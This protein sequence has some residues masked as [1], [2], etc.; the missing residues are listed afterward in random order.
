MS[1]ADTKLTFG[2]PHTNRLT[3]MGRVAEPPFARHDATGAAIIVPLNLQ[4]HRPVSACSRGHS[5]TSATDA[6]TWKNDDAPD[7]VLPVLVRGHAAL[8]CSSNLLA[9]MVIHVEASIRSLGATPSGAC[10]TYLEAERIHV[11]QTTPHTFS[12]LPETPH[13]PPAEDNHFAPPDH[14][15]FYTTVRTTRDMPL[16]FPPHAADIWTDHPASMTTN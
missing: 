4:A 7:A 11:L 14:R 1:F 16:P 3:L 2:A 6:C 15:T 9:G 12:D 13:M 5:A 8:W 10:L